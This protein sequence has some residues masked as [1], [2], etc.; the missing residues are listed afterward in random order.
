MREETAIVREEAA[1][2]N[3]AVVVVEHPH[4]ARLAAQ[5][6][7][8]YSLTGTPAATHTISRREIESPAKIR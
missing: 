1:A 6:P 5:Q 7:P 3:G 8:V 4:A 2:D